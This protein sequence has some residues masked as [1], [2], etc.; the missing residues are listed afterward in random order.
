ME[1]LNT[2]IESIRRNKDNIFWGFI[3]PLLLTY[4]KK[5]GSF[6][7]LL[8]DFIILCSIYPLLSIHQSLL[9]IIS[10]IGR[11][12]L[13][14][15]IFTMSSL[16]LFRVKLHDWRILKL[17][18]E[19]AWGFAIMTILLAFLTILPKLELKEHLSE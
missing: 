14:L 13:G 18:E 9:D 12:G 16:I 17:S 8:L 19:K 4:K 3:M 1:L 7:F 15:L 5:I 11:F 10:G 2:L 6:G